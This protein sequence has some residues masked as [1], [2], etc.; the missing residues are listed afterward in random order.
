MPPCPE[1]GSTQITVS[2][3]FG[4]EE[5]RSISTFTPDLKSTGKKTITRVCSDCGHSWT[6]T[7]SQ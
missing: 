1:C 5:E 6:E 3:S 2:T 4:I 7:K